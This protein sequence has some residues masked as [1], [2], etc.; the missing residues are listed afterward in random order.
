MKIYRDRSKRL[1]EFFQ[2]N[3]YEVFMSRIYSIMYTMY[4]TGYGILTRV[5]S[6]YPQDPDEN[7]WKVIL[8][9]LRNTKDQ[10]LDYGESNLK[11]IVW[12]PFLVG[13]NNSK[14]VLEYI[15]TL[16]NRAI[17]WK[18]SKQKNIAKFKLR[19]RMH[20]SIRCLQ[21]SYVIVQ[22]Y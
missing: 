2:S 4:E 11:L 13:Y 22:F 14:N 7:H 6:G 19:G 10:W 21:E 9:Y 20:C 17:C 8:K 1:L 15:L 18:G 3:I 5:V 12:L 16:N